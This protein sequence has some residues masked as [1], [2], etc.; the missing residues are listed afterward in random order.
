MKDV[1][2]E[3]YRAI[4]SVKT[5]G[6]KATDQRR[7]VSSSLNIEFGGDTRQL[8]RV[9]AETFVQSEEHFASNLL[10]HALS[11]TL[12]VLP[13]I[14]PQ[15]D[16]ADLEEKI[17]T[18]LGMPAYLSLRPIFDYDSG[19][20]IPD[21]GEVSTREGVILG[22]WEKNQGSISIVDTATGKELYCYQISDR[23]T[24]SI[25]GTTLQWAGTNVKPVYLN[26]LQNRNLVRD[27]ELADVIRVG[28]C[29]FLYREDEYEDS[30][31]FKP[32]SNLDRAC[33]KD[34]RFLSLF[35]VK[36]CDN[37]GCLIEPTSKL[38]SLASEGQDGAWYASGLRIAGYS[39]SEVIIN[40]VD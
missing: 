6:D 7:D 1:A 11:E 30:V 15:Q 2:T 10:H 39:S 34:P 22:R 19:L 26:Q 16:F 33:F 9:L 29:G 13:D 23:P 4:V 36:D 24:V 35:D 3:L 17:I 32:Y 31:S 28:D 14:L 18:T 5:V 8:L 38:F 27:L 21:Y 25:D 20:E 37:G 40:P 12:K